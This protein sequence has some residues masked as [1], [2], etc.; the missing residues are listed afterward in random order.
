M[1]Y[2]VNTLCIIAF[3]LL[4]FTLTNAGRPSP[5]SAGERTHHTVTFGK[6]DGE[7]EECVEEN[8]ECLQRRT[9]AAHTDYIY[10]QKVNP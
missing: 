9:L 4:T 8:D 1:A 3:L 6:E 5:S 7:M 10:T 2:K